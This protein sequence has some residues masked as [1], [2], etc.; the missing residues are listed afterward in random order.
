MSVILP[1]PPHKRPWLRRLI[2]SAILVLIGILCLAVAGLYDIRRPANGHW[3]K[4]TD[5]T[6][7]IRDAGFA[8]MLA[9]TGVRDSNQVVLKVFFGWS[10]DVWIVVL[11]RPGAE[12][13]VQLAEYDFRSRKKE[14]RTIVLSQSEVD[15]FLAKFDRAALGFRILETGGYDG[16]E[17]SFERRLP[18]R[19]ASYEGNASFSKQDADMARVVDQFIAMHGGYKF[20]RPSGSGQDF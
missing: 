18:D 20:I 6:G 12:P 16:R 10:Q 17:I 3:T 11:N 1:S 14:M 7:D 8:N 15:D 9:Q 5:G 4:D 19:T 13:Q 2:F